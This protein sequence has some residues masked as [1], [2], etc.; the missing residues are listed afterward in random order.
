MTRNE[1]PPPAVLPADHACAEVVVTSALGLHTR[2]STTIA[3]M[4]LAS[5]CALTV[6][7]SSSGEVAQGDSILSLLSLGAPQHTL[8]L[9]EARGKGATE[10]I[11]ELVRFFGR[12]FDEPNP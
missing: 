8:L 10:L 3:K 5:E 7:C 11:N 12:G 9:L 6:R 1:A 4:T 2:P